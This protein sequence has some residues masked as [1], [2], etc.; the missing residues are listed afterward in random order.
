MVNK[1]PLNHHETT[2]KA[3]F[4]WAKNRPVASA[5]VGAEA[6]GLGLWWFSAASLHVA[7]RRVSTGGAG[8]KNE[9]LRE[10]SERC[11]WTSW[12][13]L[14]FC[15]FKVDS[16]WIGIFSGTFFAD[17]MELKTGVRLAILQINLLIF[18]TV[19]SSQRV[20]T[21]Y[22]AVK[23]SWV[24]THIYKMD[25]TGNNTFWYILNHI[26]ILPVRFVGIIN[27][28]VMLGWSIFGESELSRV[29]CQLD[30]ARP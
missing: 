13:H 26:D 24:N 15:G 18:F 30:E 16:R 25:Q 10:I 2:M 23:H 14:S 27:Q 29:K 7:W 6:L 17:L 21:T 8:K 9:D 22:T 4:L 19:G 20:T 28:L 11:N 5:F 1:T 3:P 12:L